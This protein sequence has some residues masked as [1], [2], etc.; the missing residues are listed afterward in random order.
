MA[1]ANGQIPQSA[2]APITKAVNGEQAYLIKDAAK[3]FN[4]MNAESERRYGVTLRVSSARVAYRPLNEQWYF[5]NLYKSGRGALAAYPGT[6]NHGWGLAV[7][8]ATQE[9]RHIV[10]AIGEKYGWAKK[11]SDAPSEWWHIKWKTGNYAAVNAYKGS[12]NTL[13]P[14]AKNADV[15]YLKKLLRDRGVK[16]AG[17]HPHKVFPAM[18]NNKKY[19]GATVKRVK[20]FQKAMGMKVDGIVGPKTWAALQSKAKRA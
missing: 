19:G 4:A 13:R 12:R 6:S 5:W 20:W 8:L 7:D 1:Y 3:A 16:G 18:W 10:D 9:M 17:K 14:G 11:W 2:L 15:L